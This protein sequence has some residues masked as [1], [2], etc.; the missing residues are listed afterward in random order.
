MPTREWNAHSYDS[1]SAPQQE[2]G[3][4]VVARLALR[5]DETA[6]DELDPRNLV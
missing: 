6:L 2:W 5:G 3:A 4:A 1:I